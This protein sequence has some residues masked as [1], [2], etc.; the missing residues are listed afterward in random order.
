MII[1]SKPDFKVLK[2][3]FDK[4][5]IYNLSKRKSDGKES[6][7]AII[8]KI[9]GNNIIYDLYDAENNYNMDSKNDVDTLENWAWD[10]HDYI[11]LTPEEARPYLKEI[12]VAI[13]KE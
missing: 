10:R 5:N 11:I 8:K 9:D 3:E 2:E 13:L 1:Q 4:G 12:M 6:D 7:I